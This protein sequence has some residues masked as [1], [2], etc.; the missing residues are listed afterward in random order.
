M[1]FTFTVPTRRR[2]PRMQVFTMTNV[3]RLLAGRAPLSSVLQYA[4]DA[5]AEEAEEGEAAGVI[6][7]TGSRL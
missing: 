7:G 1:D 2:G 3:R 5:P 4:L 6:A